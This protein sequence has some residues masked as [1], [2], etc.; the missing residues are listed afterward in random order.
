[1]ATWMEKTIQ[2]ILLAGHTVSRFGLV[3]T[4]TQLTT[5]RGRISVLNRSFLALFVGGGD[6]AIREAICL[7]FIFGICSECCEI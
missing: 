5:R 2:A 3:E 4:Q 6:Y 7:K 1:M